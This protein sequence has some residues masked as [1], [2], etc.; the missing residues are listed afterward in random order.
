MKP[1]LRRAVTIAGLLVVVVAI[2]LGASSCGSDSGEGFFGSY[3]AKVQLQSGD[4]IAARNAVRTLVQE[5][6]GG[7]LSREVTN[8]DQGWSD[9]DEDS[10]LT[11][12]VP[13]A[14]FDAS[15]EALSNTKAGHPLM[16]DRA[17]TD[18]IKDQSDLTAVYQA[19][20]KKV[21]ELAS[22]GDAS[23]ELKNAEDQL[24]SISEQAKRPVLV[25]EIT[26]R[27]T[28]VD[29]IRGFILNRLIWMLAAAGIT[30]ALLQRRQKTSA[31]DDAKA[32]RKAH[33]R[34]RQLAKD[35]AD[36]V[37]LHLRPEL[38]S[39]RRAA[40]TETVADDDPDGDGAAEDP[41]HSAPPIAER[42]PGGRRRPTS[43]QDGDDDDSEPSPDAQE[44][45][46]FW[47]FARVEDH[48][49]EA[50]EIPPE[51]AEHA[52]TRSLDGAW[53]RLPRKGPPK[54]PHKPI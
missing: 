20:K 21:D 47:K 35:A 13:A 19:I 12:R 18:Q 50:I 37:V 3:N 17:G 34:D 6:Y 11:F 16:V 40:D 31:D 48:D 51:E 33:N 26:N 53:G 23:Q 24:R 4:V 2:A 54:H 42:R 25:V 14:D 36:Y 1:K 30:A 45:G 44:D 7:V 49:T 46:E 39:L 8:Y 28:L 5:N 10:T 22:N 41:D 32:E 43:H 9:F 27:P 38:N 29:Y 15:I 52:R